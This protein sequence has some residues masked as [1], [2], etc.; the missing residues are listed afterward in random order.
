MGG[1]VAE[2][3]LVEEKKQLEKKGG[4][5]EGTPHMA[6]LTSRFARSSIELRKK[7]SKTGSRTC[8]QVELLLIVQMLYLLCASL[9]IVAIR[10]T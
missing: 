3:G 8:V 4:R 2:W 10:H 1:I 5:K 7:K 6:A 9:A